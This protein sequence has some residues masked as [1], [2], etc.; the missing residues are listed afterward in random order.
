MQKSIETLEIGKNLLV[1]RR[2][3]LYRVAAER[4]NDIKQ[5]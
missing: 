4:L 3:A 2:I 1:V 5:K